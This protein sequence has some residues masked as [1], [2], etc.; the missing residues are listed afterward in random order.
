MRSTAQRTAR[1]LVLGFELTDHRLGLIV[2][3]GGDPVGV[4]FRVVKPLGEIDDFMTVPR[5]RP[6]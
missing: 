5:S 2:E 1:G 6:A 3:G 4:L